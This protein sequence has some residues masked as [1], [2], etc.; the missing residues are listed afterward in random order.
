MSEVNKKSSPKKTTIQ[1]S[2]PFTDPERYNTQ[3]HGQ[4][5]RKTTVSRKTAD[6]TFILRSAKNWFINYASKTDALHQWCLQKIL[7]I[8]WYQYQW[9]SNHH[10]WHKTVTATS[11]LNYLEKACQLMPG[12]F[13]FL[14][15]FLRVIIKYQLDILTHLGWPQSRMILSME[16]AAKL[17]QSHFGDYVVRWCWVTMMMHYGAL[18]NY[19]IKERSTL[20]SSD[21]TLQAACHKI[22]R[23]ITTIECEILRQTWKQVGIRKVHAFN[24][25]HYGLFILCRLLA[26][27]LCCCHRF[28]FR[29]IR[30][31]C[32]ICC[33]FWLW[34]L[35]TAHDKW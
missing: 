8:C 19:L 9:V 2:T 27:A 30:S 32:T 26:F 10:L 13:E 5:N 12:E 34:C 16:E 31:L 24:V 18:L 22:V 14:L 1:L 15:N 20:L 28:T 3:R 25:S 23:H 29:S 21:Q 11:Y 6:H 4:A 7:N 17:T 35:F 33:I